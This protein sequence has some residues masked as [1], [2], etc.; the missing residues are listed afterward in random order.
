MSVFVRMRLLEPIQSVHRCVTYFIP[1][2]NVEKIIWIY[3]AFRCII[4]SNLYSL[5]QSH[6]KWNIFSIVF[7]F[8]RWFVILLC[9]LL[10]D[11]MHFNWYSLQ[12]CCKSRVAMKNVNIL[13][14]L[15][16]CYTLKS[17]GLRENDRM[18]KK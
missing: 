9:G 7:V 4:F 6:C 3:I 2:H 15:D 8:G 11:A 18:Q 10:A 5:W 12:C 16:G 17:T 13:P 1:G 14:L